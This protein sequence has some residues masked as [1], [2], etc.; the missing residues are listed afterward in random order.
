[1]APQ[2]EDRSSRRETRNSSLLT[3]K[4][5][6]TPAELSSLSNDSK[7]LYKALEKSISSHIK[8]LTDHYDSLIAE[9]EEQIQCLSVKVD[10]LEKENNSL[11]DKL[12]K[13]EYELDETAQYE[14]RDTLI[15]SGNVIPS[16]QTQEDPAQVI[17]DS[18]KSYLKIQLKNSE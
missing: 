17:V 12:V 4:E 1:M 11:S 13:L 3:L 2:Q 14:R 8:D 10:K 7:I 18:L 5:L 6:L 16:E 9:K 15:L